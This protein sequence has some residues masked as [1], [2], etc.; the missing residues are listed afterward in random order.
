MFSG[1]AKNREKEEQV[2]ILGSGALA[3]V[4][5]LVGASCHKPK[6]RRFNSQSRHMPRLQVQS[7][8]RVHMGGSQSMFLFHIDISLS[9]SLPLPLK[10]MKKCPQVRMKIN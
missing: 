5:Q 7:L 3:H 10:A 2:K 8:V 4:S 9:L 1:L 6:G